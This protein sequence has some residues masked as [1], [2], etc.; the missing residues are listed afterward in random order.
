MFRRQSFSEDDDG[1][2]D[3]GAGCCR[4]LTGGRAERGRGY[5]RGTAS[6]E[7]KVGILDSDSDNKAP[8]DQRRIQQG[9]QQCYVGM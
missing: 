2:V 9:Q 3:W 6:G 5:M 7:E 8:H 4:T 1:A